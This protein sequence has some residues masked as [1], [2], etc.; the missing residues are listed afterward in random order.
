MSVARIDRK[1]RHVGMASDIDRHKKAGSGYAVIDAL[2]WP[3]IV[4]RCKPDAALT[5]NA[6]FE[7]EFPDLLPASTREDFQSMFEVAGEYGGA[8]VYYAPDTRRWYRVEQ[9]ELMLDE[10]S[11]AL[12][13]INIS[14]CVE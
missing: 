4:F 13:F 5:C 8:R 2:P 11:D 7:E 14:E 1:G 9:R 12:F 10:P 3:C 6:A